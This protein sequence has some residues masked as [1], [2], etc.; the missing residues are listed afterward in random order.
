MTEKELI[1]KI[2]ELREIRPDQKWVFLTK[3]RILGQEA[4]GS[5][6]PAAVDFLPEAR[7]ELFSFRF[8][9]LRPAYIGLLVLFVFFGLFGFAQNSVPGDYLYPV[10]KIVERAKMFFVSGEQRAQISLELVDKRLEEL[11]HIVG[12]N[13]TKKLAPAIHELQESLA[14]ATAGSNV[15][16]V[17]EI[18]KK[19]DKIKS[20]GIVIEDENLKRLELESFVV[21]LKDLISD[22]EN[23]TLTP[24]Q[25]LLLEKMKELYEKGE[26]S[27]ALELW[28]RNQ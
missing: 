15:K 8:M 18:R 1:A 26:Y 22:L 27:Q 11:N 16:K 21:V 5:E 4:T 20:R 12:A 9:L 19:T 14:E 6:M 23:R 28:L 25:E 13:Q 10:K 7:R 2:K 24:K 17:V 3:N